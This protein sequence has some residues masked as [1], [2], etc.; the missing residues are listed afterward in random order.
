MIGASAAVARE[1][2]IIKLGTYSAKLT[3]AGTNCHLYQ[4]VQG[5]RGISYFAAAGGVAGRTVTFG[6]WVYATVADRVH[7]GIATDVGGNYK[8]SSYHTGDSTW[9]WLQVTLDQVDA[10]ATYIRGQCLVTGGDTS[11]YFDGAMFVEG[12]SAFAFADKPGGAATSVDTVHITAEPASDHL[13]T[14]M[15]VQLEAAQAT[16]FG[17]VCYIASDGKATLV[18]AD[19]IATSS[20]LVMCA[21]AT[22]AAS[23][24]GNWLAFGIAR[25]DSWAWTAGSLI[26]ITVTG[27]TG[28]TLS[29]TAPTGT[30]DVVQIVGVATHADRMFFQPQ[31]VQVELE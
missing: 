15:K 19:A 21:D 26:Y 23:A 1:G 31:L 29:Q 18:D 27:T 25:D 11:G 12:L 14:G 20:G 4:E 8:F 7:I 3:R 13:A 5:D 17:D 24:T 6:C 9:Q 28:N 30:D 10:A 16:A 22:I 2:T